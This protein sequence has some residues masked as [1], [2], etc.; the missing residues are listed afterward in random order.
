MIA[1]CYTPVIPKTQLCW[2]FFLTVI[3]FIY[4][5]GAQV[6][7]CPS[8]VANRIDCGFGGINQ[9]QCEDERN[10]C[11]D[12]SVGGSIE[13]FQPG[14][15]IIYVNIYKHVYIRTLLVDPCLY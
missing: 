7:I 3:V 8:T 6:N 2:C 10:C 1:Q 14:M 5:S 12:N 15:D 13:C 9:E 11:F 4:F